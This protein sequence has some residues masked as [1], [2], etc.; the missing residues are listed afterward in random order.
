MKGLR[1]CVLLVSFICLTVVQV[2]ASE[3]KSQ[4]LFPE[5]IGIIGQIRGTNINIR[6]YPNLYAKVI[7]RTS[8]KKVY[9]LGQNSE[10]YKIKLNGE[11]G[12]VYKQYVEL[13]SSQ[14]IPYSKVLG[15]EIVDYCKQF[16]GTPYV[17]GG[18]DLKRGVDCS[19][20]TQEVYKTFDIDI[21][22]VSYMQAKD[23]KQIAKSELMPG[24]L[25]FFDTSGKNRGNISHVGIYAGND[26]FVHADGTK[27]VMI[28]NLNSAY[29]KRNYVASTRVLH[30]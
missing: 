11:E 21:S 23:G 7:I 20:L 25:V 19:G 12:W 6:S 9:V 8:S 22:R 26:K 27:G 2:Y 15:D 30:S 16:I 14:A 18:N 17:W 5:A 3:T 4:K 13:D 29:Y 10:W 28:S 24:D 1:R